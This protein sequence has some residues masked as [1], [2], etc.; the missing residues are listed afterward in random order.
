MDTRLRR[1]TALPLLLMLLALGACSS[2]DSGDGADAGGSTAGR[3]AV[4]DVPDEEA[5]VAELADENLNAFDTGAALSTRS[6]SAPERPGEPDG[7][8]PAVISTGQVS[9]EADDVAVAKRGVERVVDELLGEITDERTESDDEGV[10]ESTR[11]VVRV[12]SEDFATAM[13]RLSDVAD[14]RSATSKAEDVT[15][16]VIDTRVRIRAQEKSLRRVEQLLAR[17]TSIRDIVSIEAQLT[18]RQ[19]DLDS[20]KGRMAY[21]SDRTSLGTITVRVD[22][23]LEPVTKPEPK[24]EEAG[25]VAGL[26]GG[27]K[28]LTTVAVGLATAAGALLPFAVVG[29]LLGWPLLVLARRVNARRTA[30]TPSAG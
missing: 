10:M 12:P 28:A 26:S 11:M 6:A 20:L 9:L 8:Q 1:L 13:D 25:F 3:T 16:E 17:A 23:T 15:T 27:W 24:E 30:R 2:D 19:A 7:Q 18:R 5:P 22:R 29:V 14:L 4:E 21:L